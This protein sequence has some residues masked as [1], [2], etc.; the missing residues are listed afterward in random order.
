MGKGDLEIWDL[1]VARPEPPAKGVAGRVQ[2]REPPAKDVDED[3]I[4]ARPGG[5]S[6]FAARLRCSIRST[7]PGLSGSVKQA[8]VGNL[9]GTF[10]PTITMDVPADAFA[11][12]R[13]SPDEFAREMRLAAAMLWYKKRGDSRDSNPQSLHPPPPPSPMAAEEV[14]QW[15]TRLADGDQQAA[16]AALGGVLR[17]AGALCAAEADR[18]ALPGG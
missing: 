11:A 9:E 6:G 12:L 15:I 14:T 16:C 1:G 17:Q 8:A 3:P 18:P 10:V 7:P 2:R 5:E 4:P 13:R